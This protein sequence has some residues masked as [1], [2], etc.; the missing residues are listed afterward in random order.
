MGGVASRV[1]GASSA[2]PRSLLAA[3]GASAVFA[4]AWTARS[5]NSGLLVTTTGNSTQ[6]HRSVPATLALSL[7]SNNLS[8]SLLAR[9]PMHVAALDS[10]SPRDAKRVLQLG[11]T[12]TKPTHHVAMKEA[13]LAAP[14]ATRRT[15]LAASVA[16]TGSASHSHSPD[17]IIQ[18]AVSAHGRDHVSTAEAYL[19][20]AR[21]VSELDLPRALAYAQT[22]LDIQLEQKRED[23]VTVDAMLLYGRLLGEAGRVNDGLALL[24]EAIHVCRR[25]L[26]KGSGGVVLILDAIADLRAMRGDTDGAIE[27]LTAALKIADKI[28]IPPSKRLGDMYATLSGLKYRKKDMAS[29]LALSLKAASVYEHALGDAHPLVGQTH[30]HIAIIYA[31]ETELEKVTNHC[32]KAIKIYR[33]AAKD[34]QGVPLALA[35]ALSL[36][37]DVLEAKMLAQQSLPVRE[38]AMH[39]YREALGE[40]HPKSVTAMK[41]LATLYLSLQKMNEARDVLER[42]LPVCQAVLGKDDVFV[43]EV[44]EKLACVFGVLEKSAEAVHHATRA[45]EIL[46][47]IKGER[48]LETAGMMLILAALLGDQGNL[49]VSR[50][51]FQRALYVLKASPD[52]NQEHLLKCKEALEKVETM[53]RERAQAS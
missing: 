9:F 28:E 27:A 53:I 11:A 3:T 51:Y 48:H 42:M 49:T 14:L 19:V 8:P 52:A 17:Q 5:E 24:S 7:A 37:A 20:A 45:V 12:P 33:A 50:H 21:M 1:A 32:D 22:A 44:H 39:L 18:E 13:S 10:Q 40:M 4:A 30:I 31:M 23:K 46:F 38:E 26:G 29:A 15:V 6:I 36:K 25:A 34:I 35:D 41:K 47:E 43:A 2:I 16:E